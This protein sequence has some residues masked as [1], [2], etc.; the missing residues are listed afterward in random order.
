[1][2][3]LSPDR[4]DRRIIQGYTQADAAALSAARS[5]TG[6]ER[7]WLSLERQRR[8][9]YF[10]TNDELQRALSSERLVPVRP[11]A[12]YRPATRFLNPALAE[13]YPPYLRPATVAALDDLAGL[14]RTIADG[15]GV[16]PDVRLSVS[17]MS[18]TE[19][20]QEGLVRAG[21]LAVIGS[22]H[23]AGFA[24]DIDRS[25]YYVENDE[26]VRSVTLRP[27]EYHL[28]VGGLLHDLAGSNGF[29]GA[30]SLAGQD[31]GFDMRVPFALE[32]AADLM[33][34][35]GYINPV[36]EFSGTPNACLH[37]GVRPDYLQLAA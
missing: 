33:A 13:A 24:V 19:E 34:G 7:A 23:T 25:G 35:A 3:T 5:D 17:S 22:S 4:S 36:Y 28:A 26:G 2:R 37:V 11:T 32:Q 12:N 1:M 20:Y 16:S 14:W 10:A 9:L 30:V 31:E 29:A 18:R 27:V 15:L 21:K 8:G 6:P